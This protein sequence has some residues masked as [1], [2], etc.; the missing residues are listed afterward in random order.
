MYLKKT[1]HFILLVYLSSLSNLMCMD[2]STKLQEEL[3]KNK[4]AIIGIMA[5]PT[6]KITDLKDLGTFNNNLKKFF[7]INEERDTKS[8]D[9][10]DVEKIIDSDD[11]IAFNIADMYDGKIYVPDCPSEADA[12]CPKKNRSCCLLI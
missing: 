11:E 2:L 6:N 7:Y 4:Q 12:L 10:T 8:I 1:F 9:Y 5:S 3:K